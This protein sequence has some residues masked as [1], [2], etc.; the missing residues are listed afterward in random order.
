MTNTTLL[1]IPE[2]PAGAKS[3]EVIE[4]EK[5]RRLEVYM[6]GTA[7]A[8]DQNA[9]AGGESNGD[10]YI[11]GATPS[12][13]FD[14]FTAG[15]IAARING[16]WVELPVPSNF[17]RRIYSIADSAFYIRVAGAWVAA[18]TGDF[19]VQDDSVEV[20]ASAAVLNFTG[21]GVVVTDGGGGI[22]NVAITASAVASV[23]GATGTVV[24]DADDIDDAS[25][26]NK[27]AT[28]AELTKLAGIE[29]GADVTDEVNVT[30]A[31]DGATLTEKTTPVSG[32]QF[33]M[34]DSAAAGEL[35]W[36]DSDNLPGGGSGNSYYDVQG[37]F[38]A[39]PTSSEIVTT[40]A[41]VRGLNIPANMSGSGGTISTNPTSSMVLSVKDD[42]TEIGTITI[43]TGGAFTFATTSGTAKTVA[44]GSILTVV[45]PGTADATAAGCAF[46]ILGTAT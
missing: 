42:G 20:L 8:K 33:L 32:D 23:N 43:S 10:A 12:G 46:T 21:S 25:T 37:G 27:F 17:H 13:A 44:A 45:G 9:P 6:T 35:K 3:P 36:V 24:L 34:L 7:L 28:A 4:N 18:P 22:A 39:T 31:L 19:A 5:T 30:A 15:N 40:A 14:T 38:A 2:L 1:A 41:I 26:T 16:A 11:I 29:T